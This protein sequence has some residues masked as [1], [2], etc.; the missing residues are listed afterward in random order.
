MLKTCVLKTK[1]MFEIS[2]SLFN[3]FLHIKLVV[4]ISA[5]VLHTHYIHHNNICGIYDFLNKIKLTENIPS[6]S[7]VTCSSLRLVVLAIS[8]S[9]LSIS[10]SSPLSMTPFLSLSHMS[11]II[12]SLSSVAPLENNTTVSKNS[13]KI[14]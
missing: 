1:P 4:S 13:Y 10:L 3:I 9:D 11:K 5:I 14:D 8:T 7:S 2:V 6:I 12:R